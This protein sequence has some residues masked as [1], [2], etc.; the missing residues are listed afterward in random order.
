MYRY[1]S[2][3]A[4]FLYLLPINTSIDV[5]WYPDENYTG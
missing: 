4:T 1:V 5:F 3:M 2:Y